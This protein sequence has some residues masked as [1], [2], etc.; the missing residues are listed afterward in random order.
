MEISARK[1]EIKSLVARMHAKYP[2][3]VVIPIAKD[4]KRPLVCH[5]DGQLDDWEYTFNFNK[6]NWVKNF[7]VG[8]L[9]KNLVCIDIDGRT[10]EESTEWLKGLQKTYPEDFYECPLET[11]KKGYHTYFKRKGF[12][13]TTHIDTLENMKVDVLTITDTGTAN[14]V[15]CCPSSNKKWVRSI[16]DT[17]VKPMSD[18]LI[19]YLNSQ[20]KTTTK[21]KEKDR[22]QPVEKLLEIMDDI[23]VCEYKHWRNIGWVLANISNKS[24]QYLKIYHTFSQRCPGKY[25]KRETD[26]MFNSADLSRKKRFG[27]NLLYQMAKQDSPS[28]YKELKQKEFKVYYGNRIEPDML[29]DIA[30]YSKNKKEDFFEYFNHYLCVVTHETEPLY[31]ELERDDDDDICKILQRK[32][33]SKLIDVYD[34]YKYTEATEDGKLKIKTAIKEWLINPNRKTYRKMYFSP[35]LKE[36]DEDLN[37]FC[38]Y[39]YKFEKDYVVQ[40]KRTT[41]KSGKKRTTYPLIQDILDHL[42]YVVCNNN[43]EGSYTYLLNLW[44]SILQTGHK[45]GIATTL[46]GLEGSGKNIVMEWF[47]EKIIGGHH[48]SYINCIDDLTGKFTNLLSKK[49]FTV[50]D[51]VGTFSGNHKPFEKLK[52]M[53]TQEKQKEEKKCKDAVIIDDF[54]NFVF[55]SN[56]PDCIYVTATD[57]RYF[58]LKANDSRVN[59]REYFNNLISKRDSDEVNKCFYHFLMQRDISEFNK[60]EIP[61][62]K[63]RTQLQQFQQDSRLFF[64]KYLIKDKSELFNDKRIT[65]STL[66]GAYC[67]FCERYNFKNQHK[68]PDSFTRSLQSVFPKLDDYKARSKTMR[69]YKFNDDMK[70]YMTGV[71]SK[72][73]IDGLVEDDIEEEKIDKSQLIT[74][75]EI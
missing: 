69:Y 70:K 54:N 17:K 46:Y 57:R 59:D 20:I 44:A 48:Y 34:N 74:D 21:K 3:N 13:H 56:N 24:D 14:L 18:D 26:K 7:D 62:T 63:Y 43:E 61:Q 58:C 27:L 29:C 37:L 31:I 35:K 66:F 53:I 23:R 36:D 8:I 42:K 5:K 64:F 32:D 49:I 68:V 67:N 47:G 45:T 25:N 41:T 65:P 55:I 19:A 11:T 12:E 16:V 4:T 28:K 72:L 40:T 1:N 30:K 60:N 9:I 75:I 38:G 71:L 33:K 73:K 52:S 22:I 6:N 39:V 2:E 51:E 50:C 10:M 15:V